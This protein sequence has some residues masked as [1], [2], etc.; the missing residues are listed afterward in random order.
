MTR[1]NIIK[2]ASWIVAGQIAKALIGLVISM[3]TARYLGPS[4]FGLIN[5]AAALVAFFVP[6]MYLGFD[7]ILVREIVNRPEAE[8]KTLGTALLFSFI[9]SIACIAGIVCFTSIAHP[10]EKATIIVCALYSTLLIFQSLELLRFWSQ[11]KLLSKYASIISVAAYLIVSAYKV[12]LLASG[13]SVYWFAVSNALDYMLIAAGFYIMYNKLSPQ[14]LSVSFPL[15]WEMLKSGKFF[16]ISSMMVVIFAQTDRVMLKF[17]MGDAA[18]G[19]YSAA[20]TCANLVAFV[21]VAIIDS[22][23]PT[24][25]DSKKT[26]QAA[27]EFKVS[28]L[29]SIII[30]ASLCVSLLLA[31]CSYPVVRILYGADYLPAVNA[32]RIIVWYTTFSYLGSVRNIWIVAEGKERVLWIINLSGALANVAL[33]FALIPLWGIN[34]AALASLLTQIFTNVIIGYIIRYISPNNALMLRGLS[35][36]LVTG[37]SREV[38]AM[39]RDRFKKA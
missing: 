10:G 7:S 37:I 2:N 24:I 20:V 8:G 14:R 29:Y 39:L 28:Q 32:L 13:K 1:V 9:S 16:I 26:D 12:Y 31:I 33:N 30:Y 25:F 21:F 23:R 3:L 19:Y 18:V 38:I 11:A 34:G 5:Y 17:M 15:G 4:N 27:F 6:V 22:M 36:K 35:P